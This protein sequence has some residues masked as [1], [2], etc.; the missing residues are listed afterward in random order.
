MEDY[1]GDVGCPGISAS[2]IRVGTKSE[3]GWNAIRA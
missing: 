3:M 2:A 1:D